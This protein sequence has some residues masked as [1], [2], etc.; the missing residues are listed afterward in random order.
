MRIARE[1]VEGNIT[2]AGEEDSIQAG[3]E[4]RPSVICNQRWNEHRHTARLHDGMDVRVHEI[5]RGMAVEV[6]AL[7]GCNANDRLHGVDYK[8]IIAL[9][10]GA[11]L[12]GRWSSKASVLLARIETKA[13]VK[14]Q[15]QS[16]LKKRAQFPA[17]FFIPDYC[18][19]FCLRRA[20][21]PVRPRMKY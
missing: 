10:E 16:P 8:P 15:K 6:L 13:E 9:T 7:I 11:K 4:S 12:G 3:I 14:A 19:N 21:L 20:D 2:T 17:L 1:T 18:S 5:R